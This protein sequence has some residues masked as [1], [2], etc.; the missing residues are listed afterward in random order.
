MPG[1][2][3]TPATDALPVAVQTA[4]G[5][6]GLSASRL[7]LW[8][9]PAEGGP[10]TV[11]WQAARAVQPASLMKV[12]TSAAALHRLGTTHRWTT[13]IR[14]ERAPVDG[15]LRGDLHLKGH[16]DPRLTPE[17]LDQLLEQWRLMGVRD[18]QG[19]IL[20]DRSAYALPPR[21][22]ADF[23]QRPQE[24]YNVQPD[25]LNVN[26][27]SLILRFRPLPDGRR[28][29][30]L[31]EPAHFGRSVHD[32]VTLTTGACGDWRSGLKVRLDPSDTVYIE[33]VYPRSCGEKNWPM[34][35][36]DPAGAAG[37]AIAARW[38]ASGGRLS[39]EVRDRPVGSATQEPPR[40]PLLQASF[41][42]PALS[43]VLHDMNK[44]S[45]NTMADQVFLALSPTE[46]ATW[47][48]AR[49]VAGEMLERDVG[50]PPLE[51]VLDNGSGL[52]R[53]ARL[54]ARCLGEV[55]RWSWRQPWMPELMASLPVAGREATARKL[56][57]ASGWAHLKTGSLANVSGIAGVVHPPDGRRVMLVAL[58]NDAEA[59]AS[60]TRSVFNAI[61]RWIQPSAEPLT[62]PT[63]DPSQE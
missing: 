10:P 25:A 29:Q 57:G 60:A 16:G 34:A 24:T 31:M 47:E 59:P 33:G 8:I 17:R 55:L 58:F 35:D 61:L 14:L 43:E 26:H 12:V 1:M 42:S 5:Q 46:P 7:H 19:D 63:P 4:L 21:S 13:E 41:A 15:V 40:H 45:H 37:R 27:Q 39:G 44:Y 20:L 9:A 49:K 62:A 30:V 22:P 52:S 18:I 32:R 53:E 3:D 11:A 51:Y 54:S 36:A 2:L 48:Q 56:V 50:C 6:A 23:D 38:R 28:A